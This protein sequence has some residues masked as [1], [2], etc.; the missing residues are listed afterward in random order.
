MGQRHKVQSLKG[1]D[2]VRPLVLL[3]LVDTTTPKKK[4]GRIKMRIKSFFTLVL[5]LAALQPVPASAQRESGGRPTRLGNTLSLFKAIMEAILDESIEPIG[6]TNT[7]QRDAEYRYIFVLRYNK[8]FDGRDRCFE[9][10]YKV[11]PNP[12]RRSSVP[13]YLSQPSGDPVVCD[14]VD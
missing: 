11:W 8:Y 14:S 7:K 5:V 13:S 12:E 3:H 2:D 1:A 10:E 9:Q 4:N 6:F